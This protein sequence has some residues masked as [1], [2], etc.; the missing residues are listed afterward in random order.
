MADSTKNKNNPLFEKLLVKFSERILTSVL[1]SQTRLVLTSNP[2]ED[3]ILPPPITGHSYTLYMH[4]PFCESLCPYCSFNRFLYEGKK[5]VDYFVALREEMQMVARM[6]YDFKTLYI[7]G[8]T[9]TI[10]IEELVKTI[11]LARELFDIQEVSCETNPNHLTPEYVDQLKDRVQRLSVGVQ[12]FDT[13]LLQQMNRL[14]KFGDGQ[15]ILDR[16]RYAAPYF[17]SLNVDMIFNF[18]N[19]TQQGLDADLDA[20]LSSGAQQVTFYPLMSAS[21]VEKSMANSVGKPTHEREWQFF[22]LINERLEGEFK[23]LSAWTFVRKA[24]GMIDEYIV[25][26]EEYVGI[27]SGSFSYLNGTLYVNHFSINQYSMAVHAGKLGVNACKKYDRLSQMRYWF[28]MNLFGMD[29]DRQVFKKRFGIPIWAGLPLEM[30]FMTLT[31]SFQNQNPSHLTRR[32]QYMSVV[33][34][35]E[36]FSGVNNLRDLA[37]KSLSPLE[38]ASA[39]PVK[40]VGVHSSIKSPFRK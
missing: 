29:F 10:N 12:S 9:P 2:N 18:P 16:I 33:M 38:L 6:G 26:S 23:Q 3:L 11:D 37:R 19:Q 34:M 27:G 21:S 40:Y 22:N 32:G 5:A 39:T 24:A 15:Q 1:K 13:E 14:E 36:F 35:R 4:I 25:D 20:V 7:G 17:E 28:M 30:L 8:G 31:G